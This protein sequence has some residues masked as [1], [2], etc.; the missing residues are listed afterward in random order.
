M[1]SGRTL[2]DELCKK[3]YSGADSVQWMKNE[4]LKQKNKIDEQRF[5]QVR[6]LLNIQIDEA[7]WWRNACLLYFQTLS[8][9]PI[10]A[11]YEQPDKTLEY[12]KSLR[13]PFAPGN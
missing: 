13:F 3:Y 12:Y 7:K 8:K 1:K 9:M 10:P 2:W 6:M 4:W 5:N 11:D